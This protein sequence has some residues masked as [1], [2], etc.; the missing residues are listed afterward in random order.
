[1][2]AETR[3]LAIV[4][5]ISAMTRRYLR[6]QSR[7]DSHQSERAMSKTPLYSTHVALG[8]NMAE[9]IGWE[10]PSV[11]SSVLSEVDAVRT[12]AGLFDI[13]FLGRLHVSGP[14][15]ANL[16]DWVLTASASKLKVGC[17]RYSLICNEKGGVMD[18]TVFYRIA[19][20]EFLIVANTTNTEKI[21][22]W[23]NRWIQQKFPEGC[24]VDDRSEV[25]VQL[26]LQ[27]P[28]S[29][30]ILG[31]LCSFDDGKHLS[32][33]RRF[34]WQQGNLHGRKLFVSRTG[35]TGEDGF[36][37]VA[38]AR[39]AQ[40]IWNLLMERGARPC[41][42][43]AHDILG[44][45]A[46]LPHY[47]CEIDEDTSPIDAGLQKFVRANEKFVGS[48]ALQRQMMEGT[49]RKLVGVKLP[50]FSTPRPGDAVLGCVDI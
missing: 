8:A 18:D 25:T 5:I 13:S 26:A 30:E 24:R 38:N 6:P 45:E 16:L 19:E 10:L 49:E 4:E 42:M 36:E 48:E 43:D 50:G 33:M 31:Q 14:Q 29:A 9:M 37:I 1:M 2:T 3:N 40:F 44:L 46:G 23:L 28:G 7:V 17:A 11:Y 15:A 34:R 27:G 20:H 41:G 39:D 12:N 21:K 35:Y 32:D 47:G 22:S